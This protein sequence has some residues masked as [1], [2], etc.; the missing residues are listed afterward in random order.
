MTARKTPTTDRI[1][2]HAYCQVTSEHDEGWN[3][4]ADRI[5]LA[6]QVMEDLLRDAKDHID[7]RTVAGA[8]VQERI[9]SLLS[10]NTQDQTP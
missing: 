9:E 2:A 7:R 8:K 3:S 5:K 6:M 1:F 4:F 10:E